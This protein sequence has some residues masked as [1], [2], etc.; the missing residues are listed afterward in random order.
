MTEETTTIYINDYTGET[1]EDYDECNASER[2][3]LFG[4]V[5]PFFAID[6]EGKTHSINFAIDEDETSLLNP[7]YA[8]V[9]VFKNSDAAIT[10][11][12]NWLAYWNETSGYT[13][14]T[15]F[16]KQELRNNV[17]SNDLPVHFILSPFSNDKYPYILKQK[18]EEIIKN[19]QD[20]L[21]LLE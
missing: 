9:L 21:L 17:S 4:D 11:L 8:S 6:E 19:I 10:F 5:N 20:K 3:Y 12:E 13:E 7:R 14:I 15:L 18:A 1:F 2:E 16:S